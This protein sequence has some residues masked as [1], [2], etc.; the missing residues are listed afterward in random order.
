MGKRKHI[1]HF[2]PVLR[3]NPKGS[4]MKDREQ[5][6]GDNGGGNHSG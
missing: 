4:D 1:H 6:I 3:V 2:F 5:K